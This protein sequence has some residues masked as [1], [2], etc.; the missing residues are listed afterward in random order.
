M[1]D[2][3]AP[4]ISSEIKRAPLSQEHSALFP[5]LNRTGSQGLVQLQGSL[6][7]HV[8]T[9]PVVELAREKEVAK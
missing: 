3:T 8:F 9:D 6:G 5:L 2:G 4:S 7:K 1:M